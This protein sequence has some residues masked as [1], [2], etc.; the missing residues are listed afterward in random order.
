M[1]WDGCPDL[2]DPL[3]DGRGWSRDAWGN[4]LG[5]LT[6]HGWWRMGEALLL[7]NVPHISCLGIDQVEMEGGERRGRLRAESRNLERRCSDEDAASPSERETLHYG[8]TLYHTF[9]IN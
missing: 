4:A 9:K 6:G 2:I 5:C 3:G 7:T 8:T 1:R